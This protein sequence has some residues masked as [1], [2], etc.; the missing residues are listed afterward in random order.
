MPANEPGGTRA[1]STTRRSRTAT[2]ALTAAAVA[3]TLT[4]T[5]LAVPPAVATGTLTATT[6][7]LAAGRAIA[8]DTSWI[9]GAEFVHRA[10]PASAALVSADGGGVAGLPRSGPQALV[11]STG[12]STSITAPNTSG[13]TTTGYGSGSRRGDSD[14]DVTVLRIDLDVPATANCLA[15][16]DFRFLSDE[17]PEYV[18]TR[19]NDAFVAELD[20]STWTTDGSVISAPD[21]FAFDP[22]GSPITINAAGATSMAPENAAGTT[23]DG[24]TPLLTAATPLTPGPHSLY[25]SIFDQGDTAYDSAVL[26]DNLRLGS[27][28][29][30]SECEPGA[31]VVDNSRYVALGDSYSSGFGV[32][33]YFA[34]TYD[35][36]EKTNNCQRST[37]AYSTVVAARKGLTLDFHACQ[38]GVT[39]DFVEPRNSTWGEVPQLDHLD[40]DTGLVTFSIG[41]ND[42]QFASVLR[43]CIDGAELLPF[44]TCSGDDNV[45]KKVSD[46]F[47][48]LAGRADAPA[49]VVPFPDLYAQVRSRAYRATRVA[50]GYPHFYT[51]SGSDRTFLPGGRCEGVKKADQR[52]IVERIDELN[53]MAEEYARLSGM[54][55]ANPNPG[56]SGHEL[57]SGGTEWIYPLLSAGRIHPTADGQ[58]E[59]AEAVLDALDSSGFR[60]YVIK[61]Q[62]TITYSFTVGTGKQFVSASTGWPGSDV[63]LTLVSP[64]GVR[65]ARGSDGAAKRTT[66]PTFENVIVPDPEAGTWTVEMYGLDVEASGEPLTLDTYQADAANTKPVARIST[67]VADGVL[68]LDG[69]G[70]TDPDGSIVE[71]A[72]YVSD[73]AG[74]QVLTG[75][76]VTVPLEPGAERSITLVVTDDRGGAGFADV[77]NLLVD[78]MPGSDTNPVKTTQK[79]VVPTAVLSSSQFDATELDS[80]ALRLGAAAPARAGAVEDVNGDGRA[81]LVLHFPQARTGIKAGDTQVCLTGPISSGRTFSTCEPVRAT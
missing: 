56:F 8:S 23:F 68:V 12:D 37:R 33:P 9:T 80:A 21:N 36:D 66:G 26:V 44:N 48:R 69:T 22:K 35:E 13:S 47:A 16:L 10:G 51:G 70:S 14:F 40:G 61:P 24:A 29:D 74:D 32:S 4:A 73:S 60:K 57:C 38:G 1:P 49:D 52:W 76:T 58:A 54:L 34:G 77:T 17:Y 81:D 15:G 75:P 41:G 25:L 63:T 20:E 28:G 6:D 71:H 18:G 7:A 72:W 31:T 5:A 62:Q 19:F 27:V 43:D 45:E 42:S 78:V 65:Y 55:F 79:G 2:A 39:E 46:A 3:T 11:L 30:P 67:R 50:V 64:S 53:A 59:M